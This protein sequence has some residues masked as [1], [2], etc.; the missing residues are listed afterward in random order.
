MS[1][2]TP[3]QFL[4]A[5]RKFRQ[6]DGEHLAF[7]GLLGHDDVWADADSRPCVPLIAHFV[8]VLNAVL[9]ENPEPVAVSFADLEKAIELM[10]GETAVNVVYCVP[11]N[12]DPQSPNDGHWDANSAFGSTF[13]MYLADALSRVLS[14][15]GALP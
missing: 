12:A 1:K 7:G 8:N 3:E 11:L 15:A 4:K 14:G 2:I 6:P 5:T 13:T 10:D 9:A